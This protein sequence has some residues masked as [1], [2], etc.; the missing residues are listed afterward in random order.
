MSSRCPELIAL[1]ALA[2]CGAERRPDDRVVVPGAERAHVST[3]ELAA[4]PPR[5]AP[6]L[7]NPYEGNIYAIDDGERLYTWFNCHGCHGAIGGGSIGPPLRDRDWIYGSS[8][9]QVRASI[10]EGRPNGMPAFGGRIPDEPL[11][12]LVAFVRAMGGTD[13]TRAPGA[14]I[15]EPDEPTRRSPHDEE[16]HERE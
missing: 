2:A 3:T 15:T 5:Q 10:I 4:G 9:L 1:V 6:D 7:A 16:R 11:W 8:P 14:V 12:K 13:A